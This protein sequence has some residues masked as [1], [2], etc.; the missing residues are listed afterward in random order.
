MDQRIAAQ[1]E[2]KDSVSAHALI[3]KGDR[4]R[5]LVLPGHAKVAF[6]HDPTS[7]LVFGTVSNTEICLNF[8]C[9]WTRYLREP[10]RLPASLKPAINRRYRGLPALLN[11]VLLALYAASGTVDLKKHFGRAGRIPG[12]IQMATKQL[13]SYDGS[14]LAQRKARL[15]RIRKLFGSNIMVS[16]LDRGFH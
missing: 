4:I 2:P 12:P 5:L 10:F 13:F 15:L 3:S 14:D 1:L 16:Y 9:H 11:I 7:R 8:A 6:P